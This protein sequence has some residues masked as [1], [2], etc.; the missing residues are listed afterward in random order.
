[1]SEYFAEL[2]VGTR[3]TDRGAVLSATGQTLPQKV[4]WCLAS[5]PDLAQTLVVTCCALG[6]R[7]R[8]SGLHTLR[9]KETDRIT[10]LQTELRR[11]GFVVRAE[12]DDVMCWNGERC[13][14]QSPAVI[15]TYRDHRMALA[16]APMSLCLNH[17]PLY[18][19]DPGVVSK[20]YPAY[21]NHLRQIGLS[22]CEVKRNY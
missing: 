12:G 3:F 1:M 6:V 16:F 9:I 19:D 22:V 10:A 18:V 21:W 8:I 15:A 5:Q 17:T 2:G 7:F 4:D 20:S 14:Q 11:L 13:E